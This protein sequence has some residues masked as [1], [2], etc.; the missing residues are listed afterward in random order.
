MNMN[1]QEVAPKFTQ[2]SIKISL[3][4]L[5]RVAAAPAVIALAGTSWAAMHWSSSWKTL[6]A[7]A[8]TFVL[9]MVVSAATAIW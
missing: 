8:V 3:R 9:A 7:A 4:S 1:A 6:A 5:A 2:G